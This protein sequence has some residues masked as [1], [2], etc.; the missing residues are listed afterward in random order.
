MRWQRTNSESRAEQATEESLCGAHKRC[1]TVDRWVA[2]K[3]LE[4]ENATQDKQPEE[5]Y[6]SPRAAGQDA[7]G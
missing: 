3:T 6:M 4:T 7:D 5:W 1:T 2:G